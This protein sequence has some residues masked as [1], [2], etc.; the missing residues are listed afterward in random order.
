VSRDLFDWEKAARD[1]QLQLHKM[2]AEAMDEAQKFR[3]MSSPYGFGPIR[4]AST[5]AKVA[6]LA[7]E[8][9]GIHPSHPAFE[10]SQ[11]EKS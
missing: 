11:G 2:S 7:D 5:M 3:G 8:A 1:L 9:F 4:E 10:A 6:A